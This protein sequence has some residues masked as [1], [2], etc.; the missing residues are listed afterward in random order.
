MTGWLKLTDEQR[1]TS[2]EQASI[3]SG[4]NPKAIEKDWWVTLT[5][6]VLFEM[7]LA[8]HFIFKGGTSLSKGFKLI[9]RFSEDIDIA[10]D[11]EAFECIYKANPSMGYV[12]QVKKKGCKFT[13]IIIKNALIANLSDYGIGPELINVTEEKVADNFPDKDP[14]TVY[15]EYRSLYPPH[16]YLAD[17]VKVEFG[18]RSLREPYREVSIQSILWEAF[19]N[20]AYAEIPFTINA[21]AP[22]KTFLEKMFLLH[23]KFKR[24]PQDTAMAERHSR[25]LY[26]LIQ[27]KRKGIVKTVVADPDLY[28]TVVEHR[29]HWIGLKDIVYDNHYPASLSFIPPAHMMQKYKEDYEIMRTEMIYGNS[30]D[31]EELIANLKELNEDVS[32]MPLQKW[33]A[34]PNLPAYFFSVCFFG[35]FAFRYNRNSWLLSAL[36]KTFIRSDNACQETCSV[37]SS[38]TMLV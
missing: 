2:L 3:N 38:P 30:P 34:A 33:R 24:F 23:E 11:P 37:T 22:E 13:S 26:D 4:I 1:R 36:E 15:L 29:R 20:A 6:K 21:A 31:F 28:K 5:L 25:H 16:N 35:I 17:K 12:K 27:M 14:Q 19:P 18:V 7:P 32:R 8:R 9:E 10:L